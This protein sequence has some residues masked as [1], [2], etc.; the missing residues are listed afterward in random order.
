MAT[1][2]RGTGTGVRAQSGA[3]TPFPLA[4]SMAA[5]EALETLEFAATLALV[6][7]HAAGPLGAARVAARRPAT[8]AA[9]IREELAGVGEVLALLRRE[10]G[11]AVQP[12]PA[13][14]EVL[15]RLRL[16]GSVLEG[17]EL[18][19]IR[20][21]LSAARALGSE[22]R[23]VAAAAPRLAMLAAAPP[24]RGLERRLAESIDEDTGELLD[25]ASPALAAARREVHAARERLLRKLETILRSLDAQAV[26]SG[27]TVTVREGRYVIP[28]RRDSRQRPDGIVHDESGSAGTLF[29]EPS[30]AVEYG[31]AFRAALAEE[32]R[33]ALRV[34]R[35]LTDLLRPAHPMLQACHEM[36]VVVD[37]LVARARYAHACASEPPAIAAGGALVLH[38][39]RHPLLLARLPVVVP[40]DLVLPEGARTLLVSGPN[41]GGKTVLLKTVGLVVALAQSGII[42]PVGAGST[43][44]V[45]GRLFADIGDHQS[46][47]ADLSTFS[48]HLVLLRRVLEEADGATLVLLDEIGSG[49]DPAEG[50]ALAAATLRAL[51]S[52]GV[53]TL[54]T[55]HLGALKTL[56]SRTTGVVNGSLQFDT[57]TLSPTYRFQ[58][59]VPGRSYGLAIARR[60]G[61]D[62]GVLAE[63]EASVPAAERALESLLADVEARDLE[64]RARLSVLA[65]AETAAADLARDLAG[66]GE[67]LSIR[68]R[69]LRAQERSAERRAREQARALLLDA[70]AQ[71]EA[72]LARAG[73]AGDEAAAREARRLVESGAEAAREALDALA[74]I[75]E[76]LVPAGGPIAIG[77]RVRTPTGATGR[78]LEV[79][80]DG[81]LVVAAGAVRLVVPAEG[82]QPVAEQ[83]PSEPARSAPAS[84]PSGEGNA[85]ME[86]DLRGLRADEAETTTLA[87][88]DAAALAELPHLRIIHGMGTG[89]VRDRVQRVLRA[90]RRVARFAFAPRNQGGTGVTL[91]EFAP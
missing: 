35:E 27:A 55:T 56:A 84:A 71:V 41:T 31:N 32:Q 90:D 7:G 54:A 77:R 9:W 47:A 45:F 29:L 91:V 75:G 10:D 42:P 38:G 11:I 28:V 79:R 30:G 53:M 60:L 66:R 74:D 62:P 21:T 69:E 64:L 82:V 19:A 17:Q 50:A 39:A 70:R 88:L 14:A 36:C 87:A 83:A 26:P 43:L 16:E 18:R 67:A 52:R 24:D 65:A 3:S 37:D 85:P 25:T 81:R 61:I 73:A 2:L 59:G 34:Y 33:E 23:R 49:T 13:L 46:I 5:E 8:D 51:T 6:S 20:R 76:E 57:A 86:I 78:V 22:V 80:G 15:A 44:P 4:V 72:A 89:V 68:E 58:V 1:E 63:A 40:F 48:A 12:V